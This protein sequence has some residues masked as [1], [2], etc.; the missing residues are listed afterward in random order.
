MNNSVE[1]IST[2]LTHQHLHNVS[3]EKLQHLANEHPYF[4]V[5]QYLLAKKL[6]DE[7]DERF[8]KQAQKTAL[9]FS[10]HYL[11]E[12]NLLQTLQAPQEAAEV[13]PHR[14]EH[15]ASAIHEASTIL[16]SQE[17]GALQLAEEITVTETTKQQPVEENA[18]SYADNN[19]NE[20]DDVHEK[21]FQNI[22]AMLDADVKEANA[23]V[24]DASIP[25][26]P[27]H[28]IDYFASQGIKLDLDP[29]PQDELAKNVRKFTQWLKHMKKLGPEDSIASMVPTES[30]T[31]IQRIAETSNTV[32]EVVTEAMASVLEKQGKKS[33]AIELYNKLST[34]YP[35]KSPYFAA[36]IENLKA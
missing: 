7:D 20:P 9:Y 26:D 25:I 3:L 36:K 33:K 21:M 14:V 2:Y 28:T 30:E 10:N 27:Y 16:S 12:H 31:Q 17:N 35:H 1:K 29:N 6:K 11:L 34:L 19:T 13:V 4:P 23:D 5:T 18:F 15:E 22:K 8:I 32:K 24:K